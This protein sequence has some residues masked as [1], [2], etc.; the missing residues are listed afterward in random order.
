MLHSLQGGVAYFSLKTLIKMYL[1]QQEFRRQGFRRVLDYCPQWEE[2]E[3][4]EEEDGEDTMDD[5][6]Q[7]VFHA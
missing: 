5:D 4:E 3:E 2:E 1:R 7:E 6:E